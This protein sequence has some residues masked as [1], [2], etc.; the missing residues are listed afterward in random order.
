MLFEIPYT[1]NQIL[2][3][4]AENVGQIPKT[5]KKD[6]ERDRL[7]KW[8]RNNRERKQGIEPP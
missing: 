5:K 3:D 1:Q 2:V 6:D 8:V 7:A 4:S